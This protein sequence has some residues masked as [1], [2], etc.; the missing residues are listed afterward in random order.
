M[1]QIPVQNADTWY[2][3]SKTGSLSCADENTYEKY[4]KAHKAEEVKKQ[5]FE[6]LQN[7]VSLLKSDMS[8]IKSLLK[9]L[10]NN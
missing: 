3:D 1:S 8:E 10:A 7:D 9:K 2:R 4:M 5:E 6:A